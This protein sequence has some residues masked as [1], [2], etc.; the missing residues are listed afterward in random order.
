[1]AD[2]FYNPAKMPLSLQNAKITV[3]FPVFRTGQ[4][5]GEHWLALPYWFKPAI[6]LQ[7]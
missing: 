1:M 2:V 5:K 3:L 7:K 4:K 6:S